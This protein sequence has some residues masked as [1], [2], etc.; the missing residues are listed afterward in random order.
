MKQLLGW[1]IF[2]KIHKQAKEAVNHKKMNPKDSHM[3][4]G[5]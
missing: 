2:H 4:P 1:E 3:N 5:K